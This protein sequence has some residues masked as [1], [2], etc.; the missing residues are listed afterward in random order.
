MHVREPREAEDRYDLHGAEQPQPAVDPDLEHPDPAQQPAEHARPQAGVLGDQPDIGKGEPHVE[1]ERCRQRGGHRVA[2]LVEEDEG[3]DQQRLGN[4]GARDEL[5]ER[6]D[7][8]LGQRVRRRPRQR[9]LGN[10]EGV[11]DAGQHEQR[12][13]RENRLPGQ[14]I[15][16]YER[17]RT[18]YQ[19]GNAISLHMDRVPKSQLGIRQ[20]LA[21]IR[22]ENDVL[23]RGEKRNR[24]REIGDRPQVEPRRERAE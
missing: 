10:Q 22:I 11:D 8:G 19:A 5:V 7:H 21:A 6:L 15:S 17:E 23:G 20:E 12:S 14:Q 4:A 2:E 16:K 3:E 18:G 1:I 13:N 24:G 9:G